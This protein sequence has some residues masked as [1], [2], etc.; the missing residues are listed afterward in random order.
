MEITLITLWFRKLLEALRIKEGP[1]PGEKVDQPMERR[2][3]TFTVVSDGIRIRGWIL[4]PVAK[5]ARL[6]PVVVICHGIPGS[7]TARP[8][9]DPGYEGFAQELVDTGVAAVVFNFR[10]CGDSGGDF[11]MMGWTRDLDAV[12]DRV[13][14]TPH[15]DPTRVMLLGFSGGGA[16][17]IKVAA[18]NPKVYALASVSAPAH[19]EIFQ[20]TPSEIIDDFRK[21]GLLKDPSF[22]QNVERWIDGF[23][24]IEP[25]RWIAYFKGKWAL[26]L[27]GDQ[28]EL[29]PVA[30][31]HELAQH[32]PA[33]TT[34]LSIILGGVHRLRLDPRCVEA[35]KQWI[36]KTLL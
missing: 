12:L 34:E 33:G 27:H 32:A 1:S 16:A 2:R 6:Y 14:N 7:G 23:R 9:N 20:T 11:D 28:D 18:D 21:R 4:F 26:I 15:L 24:E 13:L 5:P 36:S 10:G 8:R 22:P 30:H 29:I 3:E 19:F 35:L 31:A 25:R 17:A